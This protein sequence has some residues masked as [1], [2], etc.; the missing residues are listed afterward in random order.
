MII[1]NRFVWFHFP[2]TAGTESSIV[3]NKYLYQNIILQYNQKT[4][5]K[6]IH[7]NEAIK[8]YPSI[9][10]LPFVIGIRKLPSW[11]SSFNRHHF[12]SN[13]N[14]IYNNTIFDVAAFIKERSRQGL[15]ISKPKEITK[16]KK[17]HWIPA[18]QILHSWNIK[19][20]LNKLYFIRQEY[21]QNDL[22]SLIKTYYDINI[23]RKNMF[24]NKNYAF[25]AD[26]I[27]YDEQHIKNIYKKNP[28]WT[29]IEEKIY[30]K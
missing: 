30:E 18:D 13:Y 20:Y 3:F 19:Q 27:E 22:S 6:H 16:C 4:P 17:E 10:N 15:I 5:K 28:S 24:I 21:L 23:Q 26:T 9:K 12:R 14:Q 11:I 25:P 1:T 7:I 2:K 29:K 8:L